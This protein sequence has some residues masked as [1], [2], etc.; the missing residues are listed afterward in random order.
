MQ[1][2]IDS[3]FAKPL[4]TD[5]KQNAELDTKKSEIIG[6][7]DSVTIPFVPVIPSINPNPMQSKSSSLLSKFTNLRSNLWTL[8]PSTQGITEVNLPDGPDITQKLRVSG[9][10]PT[11]T[12]E[13]SFTQYP[14]EVLN[15]LYEQLFNLDSD[16]ATPEFLRSKIFYDTHTFSEGFEF[17]GDHEYEGHQIIVDEA[18]NPEVVAILAEKYTSGEKFTALENL[19]ATTACVLMGKRNI[20]GKVNSAS[21]FLGNSF[22]NT[23]QNYAR[24]KVLSES[25]AGIPEL[26]PGAEVPMRLMSEGTQYEKGDIIVFYQNEVKIVHRVEHVYTFNGE[27]FYVTEGVNPETNPLVDISPVSG[28]DI[29]GIVDLSAEAFITIEEILKNRFVPFYTAYGMPSS[30]QEKPLKYLSYFKRAQELVNF[31]SKGIKPQSLTDREARLWYLRQEYKMRDM[32]DH[33]LSL[34][35]QAVQ[36]FYLRNCLR[37]KARD[38]MMNQKLAE[39][40]RRND[41]NYN[42]DQIVQRTEDKGFTGSG[43]WR[44]IIES[45]MRSRQEANDELG[46]SGW[47]VYNCW[48][49]Y[50]K[51]G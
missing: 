1:H 25:M 18:V 46:V 39:Y 19:I 12:I 31:F 42:W 29:I 7:I 50:F 40:L 10:T 27:T 28:K 17:L 24:L 6:K 48:W 41:K 13:N 32:L 33:S 3:V 36:A 49:R 26:Q 51:I 15:Y 20:E 30:T 8:N 5:Q 22:E 11:L 23:E 45:S 16:L 34:N 38:L 43:I 14:K 37:S 9:I 21:D 35:F 2:S 47:E 4:T 44:E